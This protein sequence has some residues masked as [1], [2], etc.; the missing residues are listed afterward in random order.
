M[1]GFIGSGD[2]LLN[3]FDPVTDLPQGWT[4]AL[5]AA[6]FSIQAKSN[7]VELKSKSRDNY[8]SIIGSVSIPDGSE[9]KLTLRDANKDTLSFLFLGSLS[10]IAQGTGNVVGEAITLTPGYG[11]SASKR[12]I[13]TPVLKGLGAVVTGAIAGTTLTV[14][15]VASG[16]LQVGQVI[17]GT[18]V[19][20][21]T[22]ITA[23]LTGTGGTGTYTVSVSQTAS[24]TTI[25][26]TGPT[27]VLNTDYTLDSRNGIVRA[28]A[29]GALASAVAAAVGGRMGLMLDYAYAA[30]GGTRVSGNTTPRLVCAVKFDGKNQESGKLA[31]AEIARV[32]LT[33]SAGFDFLADSWNEVPLDGR[34]VKVA[35][36]T[37]DFIVDLPDA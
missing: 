16:T 34:I 30:I 36:G 28:V 14:S 20:V 37:E 2:V 18:G 10:T 4:S 11:A 31:R 15:A 12:N 35:G 6:L 24:S 9:F 22:T 32:V 23:A 26:A 17:A 29:G 25:T 21:G 3:R 7:L 1:S 27:Y 13:N 8:G 19:T 5:E 33:P